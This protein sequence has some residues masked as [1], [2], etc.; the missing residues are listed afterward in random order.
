MCAVIMPLNKATISGLHRGSEDMQNHTLTAIEAILRTDAT[1]SPEDRAKIR[2]AIT[3]KPKPP[4]ARDLTA[5]RILTRAETAKA[6]G[7]S[8]RLIDAL[9]ASGSL[10]RVR[11]PGRVRGCGFRS[12]DVRRL[13]G[14]V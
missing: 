7:R 1:I 4:Q 12:D 8:T 13:L 9:A 6:F 11:L 5:L 2:E 14:G 10:P 3:A